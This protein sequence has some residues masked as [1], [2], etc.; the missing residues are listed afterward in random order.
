MLFRSGI[1]LIVIDFFLRLLMI[2]KKVAAKYTV[3]RSPSSSSGPSDDDENQ[4]AEDTPLLNTNNTSI[5]NPNYRLPNPKSRITKSLPILLVLRDPALLTAFF[6]AFIQALLLGAFDATIPLVA[7][8]RYNFDSLRAGL[9]FLPLGGAD[10]ILGPVFGWCVDRWGTRP[11]SILGF[12]YLVPALALLRLPTATLSASAPRG[13][14]IALYA[15]LLALNGIGLA[16]IN[17]TSVVES[18]NVLEL[19]WKANEAL[20]ERQAPYAQLYAI[21]SMMWSAGL[22]V[23]P[24]VSAVLKE[25]CGYGDMNAVL[26]GVCG[27]TAVLAWAFVGRRRGGGGVGR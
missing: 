5:P 15:S 12:T 22:T 1:A 6:M 10:F 14:Q 18:G 3:F 20:F 17:S 9:L 4:P 7:N 8:Q 13:P 27:G 19:Y 21:S 26:A 25:R 11:F 16:S 2:E 23:G 24:V